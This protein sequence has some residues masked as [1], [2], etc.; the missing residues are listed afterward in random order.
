MPGFLV[1]P[2]SNMLGPWTSTQNLAGVGPPTQTWS[3]TV[4]YFWISPWPPWPYSSSSM[5]LGHQHSPRWTFG[6]WWYIFWWLFIAV[7]DF[8]ETHPWTMPLGLSVKYSSN[9]C[10]YFG[11]HKSFDWSLKLCSIFTIPE[12]TRQQNFMLNKYWGK[13]WFRRSKLSLYLDLIFFLVLVPTHYYLSPW[14]YWSTT[15][16]SMNLYF[17]HSQRS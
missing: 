14:D 1:A 8:M 3:W 11:K 17:S 9:S 7:N 10:R 6:F 12:F 5:A 15:I 2:V 13:A 4:S 16:L